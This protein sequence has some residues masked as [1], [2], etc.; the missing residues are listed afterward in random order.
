[1]NDNKILHEAGF[2][3]FTLGAELAHAKQLVFLFHGYGV[4]AHYMTKPALAVLNLLPEACCVL[5]QA[6]DILNRNRDGNDGLLS[7]P[8]SVRAQILSEEREWFGLGGKASDYARRM[9]ALT[10]RVNHF[11]H[12]IQSR[13]NIADDKIAY[14]GFS[15]G[16]GVAL[17]SAFM[18]SH[19][20]GCVVGHSTIY[21]PYDDIRSA[22]P[23][24]M[25][26]GE[27]D[28][29]ISQERYELSRRAILA[30]CPDVT[31]EIVLELEHKTNEQSR[32]ICASF[33]AQLLK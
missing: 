24:L 26:Y 28:G 13:T 33:I 14:Y 17:Y 12:E 21:L 20:M 7:M 3:Y 31:I 15:Q 27:K 16:G 6:P 4:N 23:V 19:V 25:I 2:D 29:D 32:A 18:R 8:A 11:V 30:Q 10:L 22:P 9:V 1:M 5:I